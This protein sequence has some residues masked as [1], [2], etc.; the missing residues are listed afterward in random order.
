MGYLNNK[1]GMTM[2]G[3]TP[4]GTCPECAVAHAP[5][6]PHNR[7]SL[8]YQYKFYDAHG[9]WPTWEDAMTDFDRMTTA[10]Y[11]A[12]LQSLESGKPEQFNEI[13]FLAIRGL[14]NFYIREIGPKAAQRAAK[15]A[16]VEVFQQYQKPQNERESGR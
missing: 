4:P 9:R 2:I 15:K 7:D 14:F 3:A 5:D 12:C 13:A 11:R 8:C 10:E 1:H 6:Q 16:Y